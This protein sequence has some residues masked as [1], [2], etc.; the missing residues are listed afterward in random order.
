MCYHSKS[1]NHPVMLISRLI[2]LF[3]SPLKDIPSYF[4]K[5]KRKMKK[6]FPKD[7]NYLKTFPGGHISKIPMNVS[8]NFWLGFQ[9]SSLHP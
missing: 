6:I 9:A 2:K 3:S 8:F 7:F 1:R 5:I 4:I